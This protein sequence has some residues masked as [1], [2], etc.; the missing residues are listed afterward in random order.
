MTTLFISDLHLC[1]TRPATT[2]VFFDFLR[3]PAREC[4]AL[5]ILG[6]L[7]E[8]WAGDDDDEK[9]IITTAS[10]RTISVALWEK[11]E[12]R[13]FRR[14]LTGSGEK[15]VIGGHK[16]LAAIKKK[17]RNG[18]TLNREFQEERK[19]SFSLETI[20]TDYV[21]ALRERDHTVEV[22][23]DR[24][25]TGLFPRATWLRLLRAAGFEARH[26]EGT[27]EELDE[28]GSLFVGRRSR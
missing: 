20:T 13:M 12:E 3:G 24:H 7:F 25:V 27:G 21:F 2:R 11:L 15:L 26:V 5:Y 23:H 17:Y 9:R 8:Y 10:S 28:L 19:L 1:P 22:V 14:T 18:V 6:D 4:T 16:A